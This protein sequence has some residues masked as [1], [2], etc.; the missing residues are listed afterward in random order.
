MRTL[1]PN[2][3]KEDGLETVLEVPIPEEMFNSMG[4]S[5]ALRWQ[6]M[7]SKMRAQRAD[8]P[9]TSSR[10]VAGSSNDQ[11][12]LLL[13]IVGSPLIPLQV[14]LDHS[15]SLPIKDGSIGASTAKYIVQQYIAATG[16]QA[17]L[18]AVSSM[19]AVGQVKMVS[20]EIHQS[21]DT[22]NAKR[23]CESGGFVLWQKNPDLWYLELVVSGCKVSAGSDGKVAWSQSS[24]NPSNAS[25][26]PPRPLRRFFQ[27]LDPRSTANLFLNAVCI[28]EKTIKE[29]DCFILKLETGSDILKAQ[30]TPNTEIVHHTIWGYFSQRTG[31]LI[32][33]EDTKLVRMK[34][35]KGDESVF[36]E[37]SMESV[38]EDYRYIDGINIAHSGKTAATIYRYG[39]ALNHRGKIEETWRIEEVDFNIC[40]LSMD[41]FLAP[42]DVKKEQD[43]EENGMGC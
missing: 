2:Y 6:N 33:F 8:K 31:L 21:N 24:S 5:A 26:G 18:N 25:K 34:A 14:Q 3:E 32:Q 35:A 17:V 39:K 20:S 43:S 41:C 13:K 30:S 38:L 1:C 16:G 10:S 40:G 9:S 15:V 36:W 12:M 23:S 27:G 11:F 19:Y 42:A 29:E 7:R 37:T 22:V 28:G 4:S